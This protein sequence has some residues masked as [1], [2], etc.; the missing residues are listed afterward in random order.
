MPIVM[1][2]VVMTVAVA[3]AAIPV[4][5]MVVLESTPVAFPI[6]RV[7]LAAV[8]PRTNP[9]RAGIRRPRPIA[10]VPPVTTAHWIPVAIHPHE[11]R[12]RSNRPYSHY[13]RGRRR[14]DAD[15]EGNLT[16]Y[17]APGQKGEC[18]EFLFH[19]LS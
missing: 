16:E 13:A 6:T 2:V 3:A 9:A 19:P 12:T 4:P 14:A 18:K 5:A 17:G 1:V 15:A 10:L 8:I 7:V 11:S